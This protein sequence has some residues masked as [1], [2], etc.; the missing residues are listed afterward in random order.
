MLVRAFDKLPT[1]KTLKEKRATSPKFSRFM[2]K[3]SEIVLKNEKRTDICI[4]PVISIMV[5]SE[6]LELSQDESY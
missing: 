4:N 2:P 5:G 6:R 1:F 3:A